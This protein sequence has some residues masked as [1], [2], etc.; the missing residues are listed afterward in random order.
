MLS[1]S[2]A[3]GKTEAAAQVA[4]TFIVAAES[5]AASRN[6]SLLRVVAVVVH[7]V[8]RLGMI[9]GRSTGSIRHFVS[10]I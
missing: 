6:A 1:G 2:L 10:V 7:A 8:M 3:K 5:I 9:F 4:D